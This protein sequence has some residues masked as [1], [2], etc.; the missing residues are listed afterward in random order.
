MKELQKSFEFEVRVPPPFDFDLTVAKPAGWHW[1]TIGEIHQPG[2]LWT[3]FRLQNWKAVGVKLLKS[4]GG[5]DVSVYAANPLGG[6]EKEEIKKI[7]ARGLGQNEDLESFIKK[8]Q[9]DPILKYPIAHLKGMRTASPDSIFDRAILAITLQMTTLKRSNAMMD[10]LVNNYGDALRF[11][12]KEVRTWPSP[13]T[14]NRIPER[15]LTKTANLG[16]RGKFLKSLAKRILTF[17]YSPQDLL[18]MD[19]G[20]ALKTLLA[21]PGIGE[22][23]AGILL[24]E[25]E[26]PIDVWS[27]T[28]FHELFFGKT[29]PRPREVIEKVKKE[30]RKRWDGYTWQAFV[31]VVHDLPYLQKKFGLSRIY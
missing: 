21:L 22:Y 13:Q 11:D 30:A 26:F 17:P 6:L 23:S 18:K 14:I 10:A 5:G 8:Y 1:S 25:G 31:Y 3:A 4:S 28:V 15:T 9:N 2:K 19:R 29:P 16:Y 27:A 12:G 20:E 24:S 7:V